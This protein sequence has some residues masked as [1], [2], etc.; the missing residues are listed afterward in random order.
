[1]DWDKMTSTERNL[2]IEEKIFGYKPLPYRFHVAPR[3]SETMDAAWQV[4]QKLKDRAAEGYIN[5]Y[6]QF[7]LETRNHFDRHIHMAGW[8]YN[9]FP[10][11]TPEIICLAALKAVGEDCVKKR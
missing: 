2:L 11:L 3:Y 10:K 7:I 1:M 8:A 4:V 9:V 5:P 6:H